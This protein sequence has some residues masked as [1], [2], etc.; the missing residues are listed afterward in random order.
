MRATAREA[1][2]DAD[3]LEVTRWGSIEMTE[4]D[5]EA[6]AAAGTTRVVVSATDADPQA[7]REEISAFG[8]RFKLR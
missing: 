2:R 3:R 7:Q 4:D 6:L 1:G 8:E 5:V